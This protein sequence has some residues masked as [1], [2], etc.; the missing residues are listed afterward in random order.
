MLQANYV[1]MTFELVYAE[2]VPDALFGKT[3]NGWKLCRSSTEFWEIQ[4][5]DIKRLYI[6]QTKCT[7]QPHK[8]IFRA[9]FLELQEVVIA[10]QLLDSEWHKLR[11]PPS[12]A[13]SVQKL[14]L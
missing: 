6:P 2:D 7:A 3:Y 13:V 4:R 1:P 10:L 11:T 14:K 5:M 8:S 9:S 12:N